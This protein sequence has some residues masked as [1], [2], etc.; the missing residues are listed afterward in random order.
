MF[1]GG[2]PV[3]VHHIKDD[4]LWDCLA[5]GEA[6]A[7]DQQYAA[8]WIAELTFPPALRPVW[9]GMSEEDREYIRAEPCGCGDEACTHWHVYPM[10][11]VQCVRFTEEQAKAVAAFLRGEIVRG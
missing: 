5:R 6:T 1:I 8:G 10:A 9:L 7:E 3:T 4:L 11:A 2:E